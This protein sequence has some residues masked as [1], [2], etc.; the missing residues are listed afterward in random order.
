MVEKGRWG[1]PYSA[2]STNAGARASPSKASRRAPSLEGERAARLQL[3]QRLDLGE[4]AVDLA[5]PNGHLVDRL[6]SFGELL[7][8]LIEHL[9]VFAEL[10]LD[11]REQVPDL[12]GALLDRKRPKAHLQ[13]V[14]DGE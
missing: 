14:Q 5:A 1:A 8:H 13:A 9:T 12:A 2:A 7:L 6:R 4:L 10:G 11:S 3:R